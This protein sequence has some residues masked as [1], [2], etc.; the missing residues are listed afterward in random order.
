MQPTEKSLDNLNLEPIFAENR[1]SLEPL[2]NNIASLLPKPKITIPL[3]RTPKGKN[4]PRVIIADDDEKVLEGLQR[5]LNNEYPG[6]LDM[7]Y[8]HPKDNQDLLVMVRQCLAEGWR[9][10]AVVIDINFNVGGKHGVHYL[11]ELRKA[12]GCAALAVVLATGNQYSDLIQG[13]VKGPNVTGEEPSEWLN[14]AERFAPEAIIYGKSADAL[15]LG[16]IGEHIVEWKRSAVRRAWVRLLS[17]VAELLDGPTVLVEAV[18]EK[19]VGYAH[20]ELDIDDAFVRT[21]SQNGSYQLEAMRT[22][23]THVKHGD[24]LYIEN[25]PLFEKLLEQQREP[26]LRE[27]IS[28]VEAGDFSDVTGRHFIGIGSVLGNRNVGIITLFRT[29]EKPAFDAELDGPYLKVLARLLSSAL[30]DPALRDRQ[31]RLLTFAYEV[32]KA[33]KRKAVC[34]QLVRMLHDELHENNSTEARVTARL[35][36]FGTGELKRRAR[37]GRTNNNTRDDPI[38]VINNL[39]STYAAAVRENHE[40]LI[41][42]AH[43]T[44][45]KQKYRDLGIDPDIRSEL[46]VPL[47]IGNSAYGAVN[48]KHCQPDFYRSHDVD[49]VKSA[50]TLAASAIAH[51]R[52]ANTLQRMTDFVHRFDKEKTEALEE[53]LRDLLYK[54]CGYSVLIDIEVADVTKIPWRV[55]QVDCKYKDSDEAKL[56]QQLES[57]YA[58]HLQDTW[59]WKLYDARAWMEKWAEFTLD[60][61]D[62]SL[63]NLAQESDPAIY[64][65]ADAVLWLRKDEDTP[66]HRAILLMWLLPPPMGEDDIKLL[67]SIARLF[68]ELNSRQQYIQEMVN[69][70]LIGEQAAQIGYVMQHFRHRMVSL[71]GGLEGHIKQL[72]TT[73]RRGDKKGFEESLADL[74]SNARDIANAY[75]KS[76]AYVKTIEW[77][78]VEFSAIVETACQDLADRLKVV[79]LNNEIDSRLTTWTDLELAALVLYSLLEN[80]L[81]ALAKQADGVITLCAIEDG[82]WICLSVNDNGPGIP[83]SFRSKLFQWGETTKTNGLGSALAFAKTRMKLLGGELR[84][85]APQPSRGAQFEMCFPVSPPALQQ[86][87]MP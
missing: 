38:V 60:K 8:W 46:C 83:Q 13:R 22:G 51:I 85:S 47:T 25:I 6:A 50:T 49:F 55:L 21:H 16:R 81:D 12:P 33:G 77:R 2:S 27:A 70:N 84:L 3:P 1:I 17:E 57:A 53:G 79:R 35:M 36:D 29:P 9:P 45:W 86:D 58:D 69:H 65:R 20:E 62:L 4:P 68:S 56:K 71:T 52:T 30:R 26:L 5:S 74:R 72:E 15:F 66:P 75:H 87:R 11:E 18:A 19:I 40:I 64:Q 32:A 7:R 34:K 82:E 48:L 42:D 78:Q 44:W 43:D 73:Y 31:T 37:V 54:F 28:E 59:T 10:D 80:A 63:I 14:K 41:P 39:G 67:D 24:K 23:L 61:E 76:T